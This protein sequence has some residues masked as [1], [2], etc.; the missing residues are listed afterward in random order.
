LSP[1]AQATIDAV[2]FEKRVDTKI[3]PTGKLPVIRVSEAGAEYQRY[4]YWFTAIDFILL[5]A[6]ALT[7]GVIL[8]ISEAWRST[9]RQTELKAKYPDKA[10]APGTSRHERGLSIDLNV[11]ASGRTYYEP[12]N[13]PTYQFMRRVGPAFG[14]N[15]LQ[16]NGQVYEAWHYDHPGD[17]VYGQVTG[18]LVNVDISEVPTLAGQRAEI[19]NAQSRAVAS[20][21]A[22]S[23]LQSVS[24]ADAQAPLAAEQLNILRYGAAVSRAAL[25]TA[26]KKEHRDLNKVLTQL[27][28]FSTDETLPLFD[29]YTCRWADGGVV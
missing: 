11:G 1:S 16:R 21:Y 2:V 19:I 5:R 17:R 25:A 13:N 26:L 18:L 6:Y 29:P 27:N 4:L 23:Y 22:V 20:S 15:V 28:V 14:F 3:S 8:E 12:L 7:Q 24:A 9:E 10:A